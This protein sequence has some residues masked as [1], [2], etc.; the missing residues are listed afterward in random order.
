MLFYI[1]FIRVLIGQVKSVQNYK[2]NPLKLMLK[3]I[4]SAEVL[5]STLGKQVYC[6]SGEWEAAE[7]EAE[8]DWP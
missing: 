1:Y 7:H 2:S 8:R 4:K 6:W 5:F 3:R